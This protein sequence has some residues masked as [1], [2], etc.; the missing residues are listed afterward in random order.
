MY[1]VTVDEE[2][3]LG[4][5]ECANNCPIGLFAMEDGKATPTDAECIGCHTCTAVCPAEA[6]TVDEY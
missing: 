4:C 3:C 6:V 2:K 5:S 1:V